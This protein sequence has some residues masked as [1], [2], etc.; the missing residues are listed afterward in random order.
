VKIKAKYAPKPVDRYEGKADVS[1]KTCDG[2]CDSKRHH[3]AIMASNSMS[4]AMSA[5]PAINA[6]DSTVNVAGGNQTNITNN[7][8]VDPN[9]DKGN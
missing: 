4:P 5:I 3:S 8:Y 9:G 2:A 6:K 1:K 7:F